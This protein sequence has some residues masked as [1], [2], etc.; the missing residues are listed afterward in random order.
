MSI[1]LED[2]A[3]QET[4]WDFDAS[5]VPGII[6]TRDLGLI[7]SM[8]ESLGHNSSPTTSILSSAPS[9]L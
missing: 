4:P 7:E 6:N 8:G 2:S 3:S 5:T 9:G 1:L